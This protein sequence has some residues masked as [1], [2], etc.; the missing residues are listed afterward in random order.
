MY[1]EVI[2][3]HLFLY[4]VSIKTAKHLI[5]ILFRKSGT[6]THINH[7]YNYVTFSSEVLS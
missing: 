2:L 6:N 3:G 1:G 5:L 4:N 7:L